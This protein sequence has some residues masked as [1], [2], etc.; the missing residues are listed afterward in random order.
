MT[1]L[2]AASASS[3]RPT[4]EVSNQPDPFEDVDLLGTDLALMEALER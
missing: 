2:A 1:D 4:H 3:W